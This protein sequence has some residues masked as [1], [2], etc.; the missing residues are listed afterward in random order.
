M[1]YTFPNNL[2]IFPFRRIILG[3]M[4]AIV[5]GAI[6]LVSYGLLF[7]GVYKLFIISNDLAEIKELLKKRSEPVFD[8]AN[9]P[10]AREWTVLDSDK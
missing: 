7:G 1:I 2:T 4:Q 3:L 8:P 10:P 6:S 9:L 5:G